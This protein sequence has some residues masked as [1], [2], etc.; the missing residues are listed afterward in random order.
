MAQAKP[1]RTSG[2]YL[3]SRSSIVGSLR[4]SRSTLAANS[5]LSFLS[6]LNCAFRR[7]R[8]R[9]RRACRPSLPASLGHSAPTST[10]T[11]QASK[12]IHSQPTD[13]ILAAARD[14]NRFPAPPPGNPVAMATATAKRSRRSPARRTSRRRRARELLDLWVKLF[15]DDDLLTAASSIAFRVLIA[16]V[17]LTL[18]GLGILGV[19]GQ[20]RI[21][22]DTIA[23]GIESRVIPPVFNGIDAAV[24]RIFS[25]SSAGLIALAIVLSIADA[26]GAVRACM[27]GMNKIYDTKET[28]STGRRIAVSIVLAV[29]ILLIILGTLLLMIVL[30]RIT[31]HGWLHWLATVGRWPLAVLLL[32]SAVAILVRFGPAERRKTRWAT[33]GSAL[34]IV[35][36]LVASLLF[37]LYSDHVANFRSAPGTLIAFLVLTTYLYWSSII[38]LVGVE[39]DEQMRKHTPE[40]ELGLLHLLRRL[41]G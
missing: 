33:A 29:A 21:W 4:R 30:P 26:S 13:P 10:P 16:L 36:W 22:N 5:S 12:A 9:L 18:L 40:D 27:S 31:A 38:F 32:G 8:S 6:T 11:A 3:R 34:V 20:E 19:T 1:G 2:G 37:R 24:Q 15:S 25:S 14:R 41:R 23:P 39:L 17:P 7:A 28:R 35:A